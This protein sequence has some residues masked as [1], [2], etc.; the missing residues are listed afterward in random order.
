MCSFGHAVETVS[1]L[2]GNHI[3]S[4][5][6]RGGVSTSVLALTI[7]YVPLKPYNNDYKLQDAIMEPLTESNPSQ[8]LES[9]WIPFA[10][11]L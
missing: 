11:W 6:I 4:L 1:K 2:I 7:E 10:A 8:R 5:S 3:A 9:I